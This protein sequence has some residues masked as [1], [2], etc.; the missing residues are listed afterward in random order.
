MLTIIKSD[1]GALRFSSGGAHWFD[2]FRRLS[3][4][5]EITTSSAKDFIELAKIMMK[6]CQKVYWF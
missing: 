3:K 1:N 4:D 6:I 2:N 5:Y